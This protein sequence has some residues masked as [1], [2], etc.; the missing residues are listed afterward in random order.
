MRLCTKNINKECLPDIIECDN[1]AEWNTYLNN[2]YRDVFTKDFL[3]SYP[4]FNGWKV[5]IRKEPK[6]GEWEHGFTHMT[7]VDLLHKSDNPNDRIPDL[8]RS[9]RLNWVRKIIENYSCAV[10]SG[11]R[12]ILYWEEMFR[13]RVRSCLLFDAERFLVV[14]EKAKGVY[15]IITSFYLEKDWELERRHKKYLQYQKQKTPLV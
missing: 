5:F 15:F 8:R 4:I 14:L 7:H 3:K 9:E 2:L 6:D 11:C 10:E 12:E 13:G 1:L